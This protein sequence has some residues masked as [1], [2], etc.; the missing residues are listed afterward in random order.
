MS[1]KILIISV[2]AVNILALA[3]AFAAVADIGA[4]VVET[5]RA[6][7]QTR[8]GFI[9]FLGWL[10]PLML[11][12]ATIVAVVSLIWAGFEWMAGAVS[13]PQIESAQKRIWA[14]VTGL[15]LA[16]GSWLIL[17]TINPDFVRLRAPEAFTLKCPPEGCP[18]WVDILFGPSETLSRE[19]TNQQVVETASRIA[20][21]LSQ[22]E[23]NNL[24]TNLKAI[25]D[26]RF[27]TSYEIKAGSVVQRR[28]EWQ[29]RN[30]ECISRGGTG[31]PQ[32]GRNGIYGVNTFPCFK[33][34]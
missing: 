9:A 27:L 13:P 14:A 30:Q 22:N 25:A 1:Y 5:F 2:I 11:A 19:I 15:A 31:I 26:E 33:P 23:K 4:P 16:L 3:P 17:N 10:F 32:L 24:E 18:S 8:Q 29:Q 7:G 20:G 21:N 6:F 28:Q 12:V 34:Q